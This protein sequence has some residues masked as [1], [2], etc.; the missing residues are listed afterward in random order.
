MRL[1]W[2]SHSL[3]A[4]S[5]LAGARSACP[6]RDPRAAPAAASSAARSPSGSPPPAASSA[7]AIL[8]SMPPRPAR[9]PGAE[10]RPPA[11]ARRPRSAGARRVSTPGHRREQDE[12]PRAEQ[13]GD[14]RGER[15]V[16]AEADL[17]GRGRVVLVQ[18][19][20]R[21]ELEERAAARRARSGRRG[22]RRSPRREQ[23]LRRVE[24]VRLERVLPR[25][26][27]ALPGRAPTRPAAAA[28]RGRRAE[29]GRR[30]AERDRARRDDADGRP[31]ATTARSPPR[32]RAAAA[33][34]GSPSASTTRLE[35]NLT[36]S[37]ALH[38]CC[39]PSPTTRN[40]RSQRS[41]YV[42]G[43][44][45]PGAQSTLMPVSGAPV[46]AKPSVK[47][48]GAFQNAAVPR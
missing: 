44:R 23:H 4:G 35:P 29:A 39:V 2:R 19:R 34:R 26:L 37:G 13:H 48:V 14:L 22:G 6:R 41:R 21:A 3:N 45:G 7:A 30:S 33:R 5:P 31:A 16:V 40:W 9:G 15:V 10:R 43:P 42:T 28:G 32:G 1:P 8:L 38:R 46:S 12:Q 27:Q 36:T 25:A 11:P 47:R 20:D 24:T 17:V 18:D